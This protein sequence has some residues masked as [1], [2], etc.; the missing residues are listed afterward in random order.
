MNYLAAR[1]MKNTDGTPGLW[2]YTVQNDDRVYATGYCA[3]GCPGHATAEEAC[4]HQRQYLLNERV[5][6]SDGASATE[7]RKCKVC[8]AW[9][10][11]YAQVDGWE[12]YVLCD[13]HRTRESVDALIPSV[14]YSMES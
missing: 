1:Q 3:Q 14:G 11:G 5:Q 12:I 13:E 6:F 7:Q 10:T 4:E 9:T 2:H 8:G